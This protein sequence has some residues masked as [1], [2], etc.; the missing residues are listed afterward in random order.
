MKDEVIGWIIWHGEKQKIAI[1]DS[2]QFVADVPLFLSKE[3]AEMV[4]SQNGDTVKKAKLTI[5][6][7]S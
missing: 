1:W 5:I 7:E 2:E 6:K 3:I 4:A